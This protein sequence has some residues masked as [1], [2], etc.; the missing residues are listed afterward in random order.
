[1]ISSSGYRIILKEAFNAFRKK[2]FSEATI[3]LEKITKQNTKEPYP[4]FLLC[5]SYLLCNKFGDADI[6]IKKVRAADPAYLPLKQLEIFLLLKSAS[7]IEEVLSACIEKLEQYPDDKY[8]RKMM[9][10]LHNAS[11]FSILQKEA[12]LT[13]FVHIPKPKSVRI[14]D[15]YQRDFGKPEK[16]N[17][18]RKSK[19]IKK[20]IFIII[21]IIL[22]FLIGAASYIYYTNPQLLLSKNNKER[23]PLPIDNISIDILQYELI[24]K[25]LKSKPLV[26]YYSNNELIND[27]NKAKVLIKNE[28]YNEATVILNKIANSNANYRVKERNEFLQKFISN[29][30]FKKYDAV[31]IE[32]VLQKP[33]LYKGYF[34]K[35]DGKIANLK[36][37]E[38]KI[39]FNLLIN[40]KDYRFSGIIDVFSNK[41]YKDLLNGDIVTLEGTIINTIGPNNRIYLVSDKI[42]KHLTKSDHNR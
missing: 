1:M 30:E 13:D 12:K 2:R 9:Q 37:N 4:Y 5:V 3:L 29:I 35:W 32:Q 31:P 36:G 26:Y 10:T 27:F 34:I 16:L 6:M 8:F 42:V 11:D 15:N 20:I 17:R 33:Y 40:Y 38:N 39:Q 7:G 23:N 22:T 41:I 18:T 24:D 19:S 25:I 28:K 14:P 21:L